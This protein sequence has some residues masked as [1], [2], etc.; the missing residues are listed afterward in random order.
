MTQ[1]DHEYIYHWASLNYWLNA[2]LNKST[3]YKNICVKEFYNNMESY[4]QDILK[5]GVLMD[6]EIFDINKDELDK[7][8]I[9]FNIYSNYQGIINNGEIVC[10]NENICLDYYRKCFQEYKNGIIMCPKYDTDFCKELE[11]FQE[12][13][14]KIKNP[15]PRTN[16]YDYN[17]IKPLP[18][19]KEALQ[20]YLSELK[21]KK[22]TIATLSVICSMFGIILI[23][24][25]LYKVQIN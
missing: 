4:V 8:H 20:E 15:E 14:E 3:F 12:K 19:H 1:R 13:Y 10:K 17:I 11:K 7:I 25:C 23:L 16:I 6:D 22:I 24:F 5:Y 9:L 18:S 21:R 2:E